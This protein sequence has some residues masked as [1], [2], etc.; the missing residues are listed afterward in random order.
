MKI[1]QKLKGMRI[2][3]GFSTAQVSEKLDISESTYRRYEAD[4]SFPDIFILDKIAK[5]F[6]KNFSDILPEGMTIINNNSG[7]HFDN[8]GYIINQHLSDKLIEQYEERLKEKDEQIAYWKKR[9]EGL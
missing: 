8:V 4:K 7:E 1:G 6:D 9:A 3:K 2:E 5:L